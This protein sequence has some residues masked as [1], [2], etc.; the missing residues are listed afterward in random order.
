MDSRALFYQDSHLCHFTAQVTQCRPAA[1]GWAVC[2]D[3]TAFYPEGGGQPW[4]LGSLADAQV[5]AVEERDGVIVHRRDRPLP[6]GQTVAGQIDWPRRFDLMQQ[7]SG[8]HML[9]GLIHSRYGFHNVGFHMGAGVTTIDFDGVIP[10]EDLPGLEA[11]VNEAIWR[12]LPV[13]TWFAQGRELEGLPYR[14]KRPLEGLVRL[15][16][17]PGLDLCACCGTHV[18]RTGEIGLLKLLSWSRFHQGVDGD[19]LWPPGAGLPLPG[20]CP[21][22][23]GGS[24][25]LRQAA[26]D[27]RCR[28]AR[29]RG[30]GGCQG[31]GGWPGGPLLCR[32]GGFPGRGRG[33]DPL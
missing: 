28:P 3:Q 18:V 27:R 5:L 19:G 16:E 32:H 26:G 33:C 15:V 6:V 22:P 20:V 8:E 12:D 31:P 21:E 4:D 10:Q 2:L 29:R 17:F 24:D 7:H 14:S 9:S 1:G 11:A 25:L 23:Y 30:P 13:K